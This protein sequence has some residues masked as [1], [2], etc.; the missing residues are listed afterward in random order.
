MVSKFKADPDSKTTSPTSTDFVNIEERDDKIEVTKYVGIVMS[1]VFSP[2][3]SSKYRH[4]S[5][6]KSADPRQKDYNK[7]IKILNYVVFI[8]SR[9]LKIRSNSD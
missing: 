9:H 7:A 2:F 5:H 8:K 3:H 6:T 1:Y 4:A